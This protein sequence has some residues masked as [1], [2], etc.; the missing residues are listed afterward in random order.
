MDLF[1]R[2]ELVPDVQVLNIKQNYRDYSFS[3]FRAM[4]FAVIACADR[5]SGQLR[6][7]TGDKIHLLYKALRGTRAQARHN[8]T[9]HAAYPEINRRSGAE[10]P[11]TM[12]KIL[13]ISGKKEFFFYF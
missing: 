2:Q 9:R 5:A 12:T 6:L 10:L 13:I 8:H 11:I 1:Q 4:C 7:S 3:I